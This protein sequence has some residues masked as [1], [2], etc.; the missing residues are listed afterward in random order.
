M[1]NRIPRSRRRG[2]LWVS[3]VKDEH[4]TWIANILSSS[5]AIALLQRKRPSGT[6]S[7]L[8]LTVPIASSGR[9]SPTLDLTLLFLVRALDAIVH[10]TF[11][12]HS[13]AGRNVVPSSTF[14]LSEHLRLRAL[15]S[16]LDALAFWGAC[17][18]S[19]ISG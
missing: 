16:R 12:K 19:V 18:R 8:P 15:I 6:P 10:S 9:A 3:S 1:L 14:D 7:S 2:H 11:F 4:K 17:A 13:K 5:L